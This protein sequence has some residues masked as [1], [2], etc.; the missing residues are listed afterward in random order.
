M[1][2]YCSSC[3]DCGAK[4]QWAGYKTGIGKT[5]AQLQQ[6]R[7]NETICKECGGKN[8]KTGVGDYPAMDGML[9]KVIEVITPTVKESILPGL[10]WIQTFTGLQFSF[11]E[12]H[13][14][15]V[16]IFDIAHALSNTCRYAGHP[17]KFYSVAQHSVLVSQLVPPQYALYGLLHDAA[18]AYINDIPAPAKELPELQGYKLLEDKILKV[19]LE[20]YGLSELPDEVK[21]ADVRLLITE[22]KVLFDH[23]YEWDLEKRFDPYNIEIVCWEPLQAYKIFTRR[24]AELT[25]RDS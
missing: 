7:D 8:L 3:P 12:P 16:S 4:Y 1:E 25:G 5:E 9:R 13:P 10:D 17:N 11:S 19:I 14:D 6:M 24:F 18:E 21:I 15:Q 20:K 23:Y 2:V 22:K